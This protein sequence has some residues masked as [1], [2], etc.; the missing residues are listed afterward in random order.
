VSLAVILLAATIRDGERI[1]RERPELGVTCV[2][3]PSSRRVD[4]LRVDRVYVDS[5]AYHRADNAAAEMLAKL[6]RSLVKSHPD[7][8]AR[9]HWLEERP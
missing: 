7:P 2:V 3:S 6:R 5:Y 8:A 1:K 4:G 9:V